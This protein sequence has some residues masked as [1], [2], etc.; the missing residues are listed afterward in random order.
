MRK[1][2]AFLGNP[3]N[4]PKITTLRLVRF[5]QNSTE[6]LRPGFPDHDR[7]I[8]DAT[9]AV[10]QT[11][12]AVAFKKS[13]GTS[14]TRQ[15][16]GLL[17]RLRDF[18]RDNED[19]LSVATGGRKSEG[20]RAFLP[21][22]LT[23]FTNLTKTKAPETMERLSDALTAHGSRVPDA[24]RTSLTSLLAEWKTLRR[25]QQSTLEGLDAERNV[26]DAA[27]LS[28]EWALIDALHDV[29]KA[30][31]KEPEKGEKLFDG[32][33]LV[34]RKGKNEVAAVV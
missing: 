31:K 29:G 21:G 6:A 16:D 25:S 18:M 2:A 13:T 30:F 10:L 24:F 28:L 8:E 9:E 27:R 15:V 34:G 23:E 7:S 20:F 5:A 4:D 17:S 33:L 26:R 22:G 14:H 11:L 1:I 3:F 32:G 12:G 19:T